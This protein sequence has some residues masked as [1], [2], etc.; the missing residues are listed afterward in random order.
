[1]D[2]SDPDDIT[3]EACKL[4]TEMCDHE[5]ARA[6]FV[7]FARELIAE[8]SLTALNTDALRKDLRN[9]L[10]S[11][12]YDTDD[13]GGTDL[14]QGLTKAKDLLIQSN[15][16]AEGRNPMIVLLSDGADANVLPERE[17]IK[18]AELEQT[19][20]FFA[21]QG[22]PVY[23]IALT[24]STD[25]ADIDLPRLQDIAARTDGLFYEVKKADQLSDIL[26]KILAHQLRSNIESIAQFTADG[27]SQRVDFTIPNDS[28]YLANIIILNKAG[29][30]IDKLYMPGKEPRQSLQFPSDTVMVSNTSVYQL[31]KLINPQKGEWTLYITG[32]KEDEI[33][34]NLINCYDMQFDLKANKYTVPNGDSVTFEA[35]CSSLV[36]GESATDVFNGADG[37]L[38]LTHVETGAEQSVDF[39]WN[40]SAMTASFQFTKAGKY[41]VGGRIIGKDG[42]YDRPIT[43]IEITV[44]PYPLA[45]IADSDETSKTLFTPF[46]GM[47]LFNKADVSL[48]NAF[49]WDK[50]A[51]ISVTPVPGGWEDVCE[52]NYDETTGLATASAIKSGNGTVE[53]KVSDS[54]G[55]SATYTIR[56]KALPGWLPWVISLAVIALIVAIIFIIIK[57][58]APSF[59]GTLLVS[60][61]LPYRLADMTPPEAEIDL[62]TLNT[63]KK[64]SFNSVLASNFDIG[65]QYSTV[66]GE[67]SS[68]MTRF[69][70]EPGNSE[71]TALKMHVP[72]S[73]AGETI[74]IG[75]SPVEKKRVEKLVA[76]F[77]VILNYNMSGEEYQFNLS[78]K[79]IDP[80]DPNMGGNND[81][82]FGSAN[83]DNSFGNFGDFGSDNSSNNFG[84]S[85]GGGNNNSSDGGI[86]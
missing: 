83:D 57:I 82:D 64:M 56:V 76:G 15:S 73:Q 37:V 58:K 30:K 61:V 46:L 79:E 4:L 25:P 45:L 52:F 47:K 72:A 42:G 2:R 74:Q 40:G 53:L 77:P 7:V 60:V 44:E 86:W 12:K 70:F 84:D 39:A 38:T 1:M 22:I 14:P 5:Q 16:V 49:S 67:I 69:Q 21:E 20:K 55:Q 29:V 80:W 18:D 24:S 10:N 85:F 54:F 9:A 71:G 63:K 28:I 8:R 48:V 31:V 50:D 33:T 75:A 6:G 17:Q 23:T 32:A 51:T 36:D 26:S 78:L 13:K 27:T 66:L 62:S 34:I 19:V 3:K 68:F 59:K 81:F 35:Y 41:S 65:G 43:P 11:I